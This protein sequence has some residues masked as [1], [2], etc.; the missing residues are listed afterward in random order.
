M[1]YNSSNAL[2]TSSERFWTTGC[3]ISVVCDSSIKLYALLINVNG[4]LYDNLVSATT[5]AFTTAFAPWTTTAFTSA[6]TY[7]FAFI[8]TNSI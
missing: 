8:A 7:T 6:F 3:E 5:T 4:W 2:A 1:S